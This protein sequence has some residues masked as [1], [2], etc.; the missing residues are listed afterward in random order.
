MGA[1]IAWQAINEWGWAEEPAYLVCVLFGGAV[2]LL[3][4]ERPGFP[5]DPVTGIGLI[6]TQFRADIGPEYF[7][8]LIDTGVS[9][10][11]TSVGTSAAWWV[12]GG[13]H[14][15]FYRDAN[16]RQVD[17]TLRLAGQTLIWEASGVSYR[18]EGAPSLLDA[19]R[20]AES[21]E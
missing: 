2:T 17:S 6:V 18:V 20:A 21:L 8:K 13:E 3:Y 11:P 7:E 12:A 10:T 16:G 14:F 5:A 4:G 19:I 1:L 15:F 9:V